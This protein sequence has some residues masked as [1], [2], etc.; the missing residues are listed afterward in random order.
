MV[1]LFN[2]L[3]ILTNG[4]TIRLVHGAWAY[5]SNDAANTA[6][7]TKYGK[8]YN[9]YAINPTSNGN[10]NVCPSGWH[11][12]TDAEWTVLIDYLGGATVAG[13]KMKEVGTTSWTS[14]NIAATN[15][16]L[17][18]A[19]PAGFRKDNGE[20][21]AQGHFTGW[22]GSNDSAGYGS[23][24]YLVDNIGS[25]TQDTY[26]KSNGLSVRCLKD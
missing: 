13:S 11:L 20:S 16:S 8:L 22:W 21:S 12:P 2:T 3:Q 5:F 15:T 6:N 1:Q 10:K 26:G 18:T 23:R 19:I 17:F 7:N 4:K 9:W 24:C 14:P 25:V